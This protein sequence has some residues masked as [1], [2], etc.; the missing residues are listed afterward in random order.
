MTFPN[1]SLEGDQEGAPYVVHVERSSSRFLLRRSK[2]AI[3]IMASLLIS[4]VVVYASVQIKNSHVPQ[5]LEIQLTSNGH[6][7]MSAVELIHSTRS[8]SHSIYWLGPI[9]GD[10]YTHLVG[11]RG[12]DQIDYLTSTF[13]PATVSPFHLR[14]T[15]YG[16][17]EIYRVQLR[18][19]RSGNKRVFVNW[20][21]VKV[22][23]DPTSLNRALVTFPGRPEVVVMNYA[24]AQKLATLI[25]DAVS[26]IRIK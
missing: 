12:I 9:P 5:I 22:K 24:V 26:L 17:M 25:D 19:L 16:N 1:E 10:A 23:Y 7:T 11:R 6:E 18:P 2:I 21:G 14:I 4:S 13:N 3:F 20:D 15:T 8:E